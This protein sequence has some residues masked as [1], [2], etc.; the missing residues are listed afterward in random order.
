MFSHSRPACLRNRHD[1]HLAYPHR[2][3]SCL[4]FSHNGPTQGLQQHCPSPNLPLPL[5]RSLCKSL[6]LRGAPS[7]ATLF[8][9]GV[10]F[11]LSSFLLA[12]QLLCHLYCNSVKVC[13]VLSGLGVSCRHRADSTFPANGR[14][15][16]NKICWDGRLLLSCFPRRSDLSAFPRPP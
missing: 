4:Q 8:K 5:L 13:F 11:I 2:E 9:V 1:R 7:L 15:K 10:S 14:A 12:L 6:I 16:L 3:A